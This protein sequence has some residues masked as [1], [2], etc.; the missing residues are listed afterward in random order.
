[1]ALRINIIAYHDVSNK[2]AINY[3]SISKKLLEKHLKDLSNKNIRSFSKSEVFD[4]LFL[5]NKN[6]VLITFDDGYVGVYDNAMPIMDRLGYKGL[7]FMPA[8]FIGGKNEW[9]FTPLGRLE[10]LDNKMLRNMAKNGWIIGS[11]SFTHTD[12]RKCEKGSLLKEVCDSKKAI[13]DIIGEE[14]FT[15]AY[16]FGLYDRR[17][18]DAV[19]ECGYRYAFATSRGLENNPYAIER[20]LLYFIDRKLIPILTSKY[21]IYSFRNRIITSLASLTPL[22]K[23][24]FIIGKVKRNKR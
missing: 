6:K 23:R 24:L 11:H 20:A 10:H 21:A 5:N 2:R 14:V 4:G 19:M 7:V 17:V 18:M 16:P 22:Y 13:E 9:D 15:F 1:M 3:T 12:L 8:G